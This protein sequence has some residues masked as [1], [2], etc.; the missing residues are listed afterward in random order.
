MAFERERIALAEIQQ[1]KALLAQNVN[2]H[3]AENKQG[4]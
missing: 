3:V 1:L 4:E 2:I